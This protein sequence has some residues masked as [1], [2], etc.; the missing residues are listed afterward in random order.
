M[1]IVAPAFCAAATAESVEA[2]EKQVVH[3]F[4]RVETVVEDCAVEGL[5]GIGVIDR[6]IVPGQR[7][8]FVVDGHAGVF[9]GLPEPERVSLRVER[10]HHAPHGTDVHGRSHDR[11]AGLGDAGGGGVCIVGGHVRRPPRRVGRVHLRGHTGSRAITDAGGE[12]PAVLRFTAGVGPTENVAVEGL[13]GV[14]V[15]GAVIDPAR[16]AGRPRLVTSGHFSS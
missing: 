8:G 3:P 14:E 12:V 11:S 1:V 10:D 16:R 9:A 13:G 2:T 5:S 7:A 6:G 15:S 4:H